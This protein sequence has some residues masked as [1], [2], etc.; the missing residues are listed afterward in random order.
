MVNADP[1]AALAVIEKGVG[2]DWGA[3]ATVPIIHTI[4]EQIKNIYP[5]RLIR[6]KENDPC[7]I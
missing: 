4:A 2:L 6:M 7:S 1:K 3:V 5:A